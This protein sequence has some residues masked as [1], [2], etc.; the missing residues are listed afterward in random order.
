MFSLVNAARLRGGGKPIG[1]MNPTLWGFSNSFINDVTIGK[2][3][4]TASTTCCKQGFSAAVG[5]DPASGLGSLDYRKFRNFMLTMVNITVPS[6]PPTASPSK[7]PT[8][9]P[10]RSPIRPPTQKPSESAQNFA[11]S[12]VPLSLRLKP[13][14]VPSKAPSTTPSTF[15]PSTIASPK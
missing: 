12:A 14:T 3:N 8:R 11:V 2:N 7:K 1:W 10:T 5:W 13:T 4:C 15:K 6:D 9:R